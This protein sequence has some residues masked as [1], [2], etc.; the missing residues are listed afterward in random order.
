[1][2][3]RMRYGLSRIMS[4]A[5]TGCSAAHLFEFL[6]H[7]GEDFGDSDYRS[8]CPIPL[9]AWAISVVIA[10]ARYHQVQR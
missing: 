7:P 1:V 5:P 8:G 10:P 4:T 3:P 9:S 2:G 6:G